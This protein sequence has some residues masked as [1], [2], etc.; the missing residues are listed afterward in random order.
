MLEKKNIYTTT[1]FAG[2][3]LALG[4]V[5][6]M[7]TA[8]IKEI[9]DS[10]LPM[11]IAVMFCG[12]V[13]GWKYGFAVGLI[14]PFLRSVTFGMPPIYPNAVWMAAEL[15]AY[16]FTI[17]YLY[18]RCFKNKTAGVYFSLL[19][20]MISGRVVW[21]IVKALLLGIKGQPFTFTMFLIGGFADAVPGIILQLLLIPAGTKLVEKIVFSQNKG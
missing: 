11:H 20:S 4:M 8:Q 21:G 1:V 16:G 5:L 19:I 2:L 9:G 18:N 15:A 13:C 14:L 17:G 6:P 12:I 7:F 10:L 3:F